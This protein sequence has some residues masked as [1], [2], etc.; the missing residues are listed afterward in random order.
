[1]PTR[2][3]CM[4]KKSLIS[5]DQFEPKSLIFACELFVFVQLGFYLMN[6]CEKAMYWQVHTNTSSRWQ[7]ST[8]KQAADKSRVSAHVAS[9]RSCNKLS[10]NKLS[11]NVKHPLQCGCI[12]VWWAFFFFLNLF[13]KAFLMLKDTG[14]LVCNAS[15]AVYHI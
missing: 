10:Q 11:W 4:K 13:S 9:W 7:Q 1:M 15:S 8:D 6:N 14:F 12:K 2:L 5:H 3:T